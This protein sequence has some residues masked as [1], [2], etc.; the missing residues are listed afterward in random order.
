V[1]PRSRKRSATGACRGEKTPPKD[2]VF[3]VTIAFRGTVA[4]S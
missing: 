2:T 3:Y 4:S 1:G